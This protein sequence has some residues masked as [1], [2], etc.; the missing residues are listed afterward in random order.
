MT[1][2]P[3]GLLGEDVNDVLPT[4]RAELPLFDIEVA[5]APPSLRG[6]ATPVDVLVAQ[7]GVE[8]SKRL[9]NGA[10]LLQIEEVASPRTHL[11]FGLFDEHRLRDA[12]LGGA[13]L[14]CDDGDVGG[15]EAIGGCDGGFHNDWVL[16]V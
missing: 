2:P 13:L 8:G 15:G 1:P 11:A 4:E 14:R 3:W 9:A 16:D 6:L 10:I 12:H 5:G 7:C